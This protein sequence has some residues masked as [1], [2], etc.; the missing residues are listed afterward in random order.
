MSTYN[1]KLIPRDLLFMRDARPMEASDAGLGANWPRPD[2]LWNAFMSAFWR[3]WPERNIAIE[4]QKHTVNDRDKHKDN[5][6]RFGAL[7]TAGPFPCMEEDGKDTCFFPCPLD[8]GINENHELLPMKIQKVE[9]GTNLPK[10]LNYVFVSPVLGKETPPQ[11][12]DAETY[13][14]YL[15]NKIVK[16]P[17]KAPELYDTERNIGIAIDPERGSTIEHKLYQAE[18]LRLRK[19][20]FLAAI[21]SCDL[22]AKFIEDKVDILGKFLAA[23]HEMILGGQQGVVTLEKVNASFTLPT[24]PQYPAAAD[25]EGPVFL[26]WTLLTP[27]V[28]QEIGAHCGGWLPTWVNAE[29]G[30]VML[31]ALGEKTERRPGETREQWRARCRGEAITG[32]TLVGARIGKPIYFSGW[33]TGCNDDNAPKPTYAAVPAGSVYLFECK[34]DKVAKQ[35]WG[36]LNATNEQGEILNRRSGL[37]G[38]KGFGLGVCSTVTLDNSNK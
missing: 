14:K 34:N 13:R 6:F 33:K 37:F 23:T 29:T 9:K 21:A 5:E 18:Y 10:P 26:R 35:L 22:K 28:F 4:G 38:E 25:S 31:R 36:V 1:L 12:I 30:Q 15:A 16:V 3:Q 27:A 20:V 24:L 8:L 7:L 19:E 2:Q 11:W 32:A 17:E